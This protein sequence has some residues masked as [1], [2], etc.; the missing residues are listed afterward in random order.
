MNKQVEFNFSGCNFIVTGASSGMGRQ[1][2]LEL[3]E[4][5]AH[6]LALARREKELY[7]LK[8]KASSLITIGPLDV[9]NY[10]KMENAIKSFVVQYGKINGGVHAA[11]TVGV[12]P[13]KNYNRDIAHQIMNTSFWA[14]ID[15]VEICSKT[16][17]SEKGASFI[18]FSSVDSID[19]GKGKFAYSAAKMAL[20][21]AIKS[22]AKEIAKRKQRINT[23][24]PG[25]VETDM[26]DS[27]REMTN[28]EPIL[29]RE[30][31]GIGKPEDVIGQ[32]LFL[33]SDRAKWITG[34][35]ILVDGGYL[36]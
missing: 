23:V 20:N 34:T 8:S 1:L 3:V 36:A 21:S 19:G 6:V 28:M 32:V 25:W 35:N 24:L 4:A 31:L 10:N 9:C 33:L 26:T 16:A 11:G 30:L 12:T 22:I 14:G 5:G 15:F 27:I 17:I 18:L 13:L 2:V 7:D 29:T